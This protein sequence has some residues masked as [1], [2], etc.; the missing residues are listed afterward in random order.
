M[1]QPFQQIRRPAESPPP[2]PHVIRRPWCPGVEGVEASPSFWDP[3]ATTTSFCV[4]FSMVFC[5]FE[6]YLS[7]FFW[8]NFDNFSFQIWVLC[9]HQDVGSRISTKTNRM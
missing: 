1:N 8:S 5:W 7:C 2:T 4:D 9:M 6:M 3:E